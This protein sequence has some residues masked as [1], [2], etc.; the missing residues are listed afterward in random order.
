MLE[1]EI[2][3]IPCVGFDFDWIIQFC[4]V[5]IIKHAQCKEIGLNALKGN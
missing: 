3:I 4:W 5:K 1:I 2:R